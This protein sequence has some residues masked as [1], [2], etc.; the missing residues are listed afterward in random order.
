MHPKRVVSAC[1]GQSHARKHTT[2][3]GYMVK[4]RV[5]YTNTSCRVVFAFK[6]QIHA[7]KLVTN[8]AWI[9]MVVHLYMAMV[10]SVTLVHSV[11]K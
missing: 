3:P 11:S 2:N 9:Y 6:G 10:A 7:R 4:H 5:V 8:P 1:K